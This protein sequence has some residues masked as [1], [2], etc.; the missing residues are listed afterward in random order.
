MNILIIED[1]EITLRETR[2]NLEK[3]NYN[4]FEI[5]DFGNIVKEVKEINPNLILLDITLPYFDGFYFCEK[6]R[7]FTNVPIIFVSSKN[8]KMDMIMAMNLG[9][10]DY[11]TKPFD[12]DL[13]ITKIRALLRRTYSFND[14]LEI[15]SFKNI[16][17]D[18]NKRELI[19][20]NKSINLTQT[21]FIILELLFQKIGS[22]VSKDE[23][24]TKLWDEDAFVDDNVIA[25]NINR[26]RKKLKSSGL[27]D[28]IKTKKG[29]GYGLVED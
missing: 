10:D 13:L 22:Y 11:I 4:T 14:E 17:L 7:E 27:E 9:G 25:V 19:F 23:I 3:W 26:I 8:E 29:I 6:I 28:I 15:L 21:E 2:K 1:D 5:S 24:I 16:N 20:E 12:M 18:I